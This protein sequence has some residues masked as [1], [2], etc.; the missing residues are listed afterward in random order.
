MEA[1]LL[2]MNYRILYF[3]SPQALGVNSRFSLVDT[4]GMSTS[5][6]KYKC[7]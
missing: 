6:N 5:T 2:A 3:T 7:K 1:G 4:I